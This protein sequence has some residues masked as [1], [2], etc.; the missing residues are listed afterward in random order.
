M[1]CPLC[2]KKIEISSSVFHMTGYY[3][4]YIKCECGFNISIDFSKC[5]EL[6]SSYLES[7][8]GRAQINAKG[9]QTSPQQP[10][11]KIVGDLDRWSGKWSELVSFLNSMVRKINEL[12]NNVGQVR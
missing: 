7:M 10:Q 8:V 4:P 1:K 12:A 5:T 2:K 6:C 3:P 9:L 11:P